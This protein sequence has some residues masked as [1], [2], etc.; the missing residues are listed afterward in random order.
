[1]ESNKSCCFS[2]FAVTRVVAVCS[3][4]VVRVTGVRLTVRRSAERERV[5]ISI[6]GPIV[7]INRV[8]RDVSTTGIASGL[9]GGADVSYA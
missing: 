7:V 1:M 6:A 3:R 5:E 9:T 2:G 4:S 8:Q